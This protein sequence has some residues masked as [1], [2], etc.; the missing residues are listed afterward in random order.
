MNTFPMSHDEYSVEEISYEDMMSILSDQGKEN[1][2]LQDVSEQERALQ[3]ERSIR[4]D[5]I[6]RRISESANQ[7]LPGW[8]SNN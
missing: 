2:E 3:E 5:D 4:V 7:K 8:L 1:M 6:A